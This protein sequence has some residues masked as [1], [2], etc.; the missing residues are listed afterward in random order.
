[1]ENAS[2]GLVARNADKENAFNLAEEM[3]KGV[4]EQSVKALYKAK[5]RRN[6]SV[7]AMQQQKTM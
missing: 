6:C 1:V 2:L 7:F 3:R 4:E 5:E